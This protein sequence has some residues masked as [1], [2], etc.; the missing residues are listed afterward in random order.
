MGR[1]AA[2]ANTP[3]IFVVEDDNRVR[4]PASGLLRNLGQL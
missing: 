1:L 2:G 3:L 4:T